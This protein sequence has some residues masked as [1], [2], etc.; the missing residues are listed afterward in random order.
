MAQYILEAVGVEFSYPDG[1][2]ALNGLTLAIERGKKVA[3]L[4]PNGAGKTTLLLHFNGIL[5]PVR[6]K[7]RF[8]GS[9]I[10]Y[11]NKSLTELRRRVGLVFQDPDAQLFSASVYQDVSF[12]P[13]NLG[14]AREEARRRTSEA[15]AAMGI[16]DL[17]TRATHSLSYGQK[18]RVAMAGVLA[19]EPEAIMF[20]EPTASLDPNMIRETLHLLEILIRNGKTVV[21]STHDVDLAYAWADQVVVLDGGRL[22]AEGTPEEV[23]SAAGVVAEKALRLPWLLEVDR[24]L[25]ARGLVPSA[26]PLPRSLGELCSRLDK[27]RTGQQDAPTDAVRPARVQVVGLGP[28]GPDYMIP[29]AKRAVDRAEILVGGSRALAAFAGHPAEKIRI[30][31][32]LAEAI[33]LIKE[34]RDKRIIVLLS[35]DPGLY[36]L[37]DR[38]LAGLPRDEIEIIP[39]ISSVQVAFAR[40]GMSWQDARIIS[41]HGRDDAELI[42]AVRGWSKVAVLTSPAYP[43]GRVAAS[44]VAGGIRGKRLFVGHNLSYPDETLVDGTPEEVAGLP[45]LDNAV[46]VIYDG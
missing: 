5:R 46:V 17:E 42:P 2:K 41:V 1:S 35:G 11:D 15:M 44:L 14:L 19:M 6:G 13:L 43:P 29:A 28:G 4:G 26:G 20:D 24:E 9:D 37:L 7:L 36:G 25:R 45:G 23:F 38:L 22:A 39:G 18:K 16:A 33:R 31:S 32:D 40:A 30:T 12:G 3:I 34:R 21:L 27:A 10:R 8:A